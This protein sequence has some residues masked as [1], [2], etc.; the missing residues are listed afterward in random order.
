MK[1]EKLLLLLN[2]YSYYYYFC[3]EETSTNGLFVIPG[4]AHFAFNKKHCSILCLA[5]NLT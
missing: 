4:L 2:C 5:V 3:Y 1:F